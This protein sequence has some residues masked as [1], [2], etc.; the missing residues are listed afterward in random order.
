MLKPTR[1]AFLL[2]AASAARVLGANDRIRLAGI[3]VGGRGTYDLGLAANAENTEVVAVSDVYSPRLIEIHS[4]LAPSGQAYKDYREVLDRKDVDAVIVGTPDHWHVPIILDAIAAGKDVYCEKPVSHSIAEGEK[5]L[6]AVAS[7][8]QI[9]QIGYQQRSWPH[10]QQAREIFL[11]GKLGPV[12][13][14][15]TSWYQRYSHGAAKPV[16]EAALDWKAFLGSAPD[17]P[18]DA[19]RCTNWRWFWDFGGGHLTD[20]FSHWVDVVHWYTGQSSPTSADAQGTRNIFPEFE[21][22]DTITAVYEYPEGYNVVHTGSLASAIEDGN[23]FFRGHEATMRLN[24]G[25]FAIFEEQ[26]NRGGRALLPPPAFVVDSPRDGTID[27]MQNFLDCVRS[28]KTPNSPVS[29]SVA[30]AKA[31]HLGNI[32][33]R[34]K[35]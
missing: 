12:P 20:L 18:F 27:H 3:G 22:P 25:G 1:R 11:S 23:I 35:V 4:K 7:S 14:I 15:Q 19:L 30:S 16:T 21:C 9:V 5:L 24:R 31:A 17:Q 32:A 8:K 28:R 13:L 2:T 29:S 34:K 6:N 26:S 10:Y 33:Y